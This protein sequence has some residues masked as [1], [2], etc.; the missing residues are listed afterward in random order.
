MTSFEGVRWWTPSN[1]VT[2]YLIH[3]YIFW[4][5]LFFCRLKHFIG[6]SKTDL[7]GKVPYGLHH[8]AD[9]AATMKCSVGGMY[10]KS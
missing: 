9:T 2:L 3:L 10:L 5:L 7:E 4:L 6:Y 8:H 1:L